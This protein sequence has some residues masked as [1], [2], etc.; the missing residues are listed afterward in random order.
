MN[1]YQTTGNVTVSA[2]KA[3]LSRQT[4]RK[5]VV[6]TQPPNE[7]QGKPTWRTRK[8]SLV[9]IWPHAERL[10]AET[11]EL[12]AKARFEHL[13]EHSLERCN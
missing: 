9:A 7:R 8:N 13:W 5:Y 12:E 10:L 3:D 1:E 11:P 2:L 6:A 4:A